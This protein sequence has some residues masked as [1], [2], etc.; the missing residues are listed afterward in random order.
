VYDLGPHNEYLYDIGLGTF[1]SGLTT[2]LSSKFSSPNSLSSLT[3]G[4][5]ISGREYTFASGAGVFN[6]EPMAVPGQ[7]KYRE[8]VDLG[9]YT[10]T[11]RDFERILD[12]LKADYVG[13]T[14]NI[15]TRNCNHFANAFVM[16][17]L[18]KPIPSYV[19]R[20]A[21][22]GGMFSCL[23][24]SQLL[25]DAPVDQQQGGGGGGSSSSGYQVIAP[26]NRNRES[27]ATKSEPLV[28]TGSKTSSSGIVLGGDSET[29]SSQFGIHVSPSPLP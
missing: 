3:L 17:L 21:N 2:S 7:A 27:V 20:L 9:T 15:L 24:P 16:R 12:D 29:N 13:S 6:H 25:S 18:S 28:S 14:Y 26:R 8:S 5:E 22:L 23:L 10:G 11:T 4:V 1:H 19:N